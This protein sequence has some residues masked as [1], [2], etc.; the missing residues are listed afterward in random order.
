MFVSIQFLVKFCYI[1]YFVAVTFQVADINPLKS[2]R[3][4]MKR[5]PPGWEKAWIPSECLCLE[6]ALK[7]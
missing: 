2:I 3:T 1:M 4:S 7:A 5:I 6:D